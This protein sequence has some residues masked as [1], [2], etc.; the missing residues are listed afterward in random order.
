MREKLEAIVGAKITEFRRKMAEVKRTARSVPNQ[1]WID[2]KVRYKKT[3]KRLDDI[4]DTIRTLGTIGGNMLFGSLLAMS[5]GLVPVIAGLTAAIAMLGPMLGVVAG[6]TFA[7]ATALGFAG[8]A[9]LAFGGAAIP[10]ITKLFD[11][12][13]KLNAQQKAARAEMDKVKKTWGKI[14]KDLE[15]PVLNAFSESMRIANKVLQM[16]RPLFQSAAVAVNNLLGSFNKS[17]DSAPVKAFFD[18]MNKAGGPMLEVLGKGLG[19]FLQGF[20]SMMVAFGPLAENT[21]QGFLNM[22]KNFATWADGLKNSDKFQAFVQYVQENMPKIRAI[23]RDVTAGLIYMFAAFGP[24]SA[25]MM[26]GLQNMMA[27]FK[28][29]SRT[30]GQ[31][32]QFQRF[33][34]YIREN[35]PGVLALIGNL[36]TLLVNFGIAIAPIGSKVLEIVNGFLAWLGSLIGAHPWVGKMIAAVIIFAGAFQ[37]LYPIITVITTMFGSQIKML[38]IWSARWVVSMVVAYAKYAW[39]ALQMVAKAT[40]WTLKTTAL[41]IAWAAKKTAIIV[42]TTAKFVA[43]YTWLALQMIAKAVMWTA[44]TTASLVVW[45]AKYTAVI[46]AT[47]AKFVAKYAWM[48]AQALF[49]AARIAA[50][51]FIALG[52][53]GWVIG[54]IVGLVA[55]VIWKWDEIKA[56]TIK[57]WNKIVS[58]VAQKAVEI[59]AKVKHG[60]NA[61][62]AVLEGMKNT[63]FKA[64]IGLIQQLIKGIASMT[65]KVV[66]TVKNVAQKV[67]DFLPFSPAKVGPLSDLDRLDFKGPIIDSIRRAKSGVQSEMASLLSGHRLA[68]DTAMGDSG[69]NTIRQEISADLNNVQLKERDIAIIMDERE[70][71]RAVEK[72][73]T[74]FQRMNEGRRIAF[75]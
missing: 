22:S 67:R 40:W 35:G 30:L 65:S 12:N 69:F 74:E 68:I 36:V 54:V 70:V 45:A 52:P 16:S 56:W 10:T 51:W 18:Y 25:D 32:E 72:Y 62:K 17:L 31:N 6:S 9:A 28:E 48:A 37:A 11:E 41:I 27:R 71:G 47:T 75:E 13:A 24:L 2:V 39:F 63:F 58:Y 61:A 55:L 53:V 33:I 1:I 34:S 43:K 50:A 8:A 59:A 14:T 49:N 15:K 5:P 29:W 4:A 3:Q 73:V 7:L 20:L 66:S 19:Y 60:L 44:K 26:T 42:A 23:F 57:T 38:A 64:G 46:V 21:A